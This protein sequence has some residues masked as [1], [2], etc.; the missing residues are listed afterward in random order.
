[1]TP[2]A[3]V[4]MSGRVSESKLEH[5]FKRWPI[6]QA[7]IVAASL[8]GCQALAPQSGSQRDRSF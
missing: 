1:M 6:G 7:L 4:S 3:E 2:S 8:L 5:P